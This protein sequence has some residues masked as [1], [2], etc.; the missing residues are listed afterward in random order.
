LFVIK[1]AVLSCSHKKKKIAWGGN[2]GKLCWLKP[3][4]FGWRGEGHRVRKLELLWW[5][6]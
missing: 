3:G 6:P 2:E 1:I 5:M 4:S